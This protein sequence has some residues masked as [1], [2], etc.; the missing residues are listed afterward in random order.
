MFPYMFLIPGLVLYL[1]WTVYPLVYQLYI[2]FFDWRIIPG[3]TKYLCRLCQLRSGFR[4]SHV[5][6]GDA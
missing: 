1:L 3:Q 4:R 5:L 6:A 2:S